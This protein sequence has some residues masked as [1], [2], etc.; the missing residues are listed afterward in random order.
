MDHKRLFIAVIIT[1]VLL[2]TAL[3]ILVPLITR[4]I[5]RWRF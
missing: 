2:G 4:F 1:T 5:E 3:A